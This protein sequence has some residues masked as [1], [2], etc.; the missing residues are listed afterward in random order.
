MFPRQENTAT[1]LGRL[2]PKTWICSGGRVNTAPRPGQTAAGGSQPGGR[3]QVRQGWAHGAESTGAWQ[4]LPRHRSQW[5]PLHNRAV[6]HPLL[7]PVCQV[8]GSPA[9][10][11]MLGRWDTLQLYQYQCRRGSLSCLPPATAPSLPGVPRMP[12][13]CS[14]QVRQRGW[15]HP[16]TRGRPEG[17][18]GWMEQHRNSTTAE[19]WQPPR[20]AAGTCRCHRFPAAPCA[21]TGN[22]PRVTPPAPRAT[23][24]PAPAAGGDRGAVQ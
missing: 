19:P 24:P 15:Q 5:G 10:H 3:G 13:S 21:G 12:P 8:R 6:R 18:P 14:H 22:S 2:W 7:L 11:S 23:C 1:D 9:W 17:D 4:V 16:V 20:H